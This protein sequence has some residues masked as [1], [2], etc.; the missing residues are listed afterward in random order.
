M[1]RPE[2]RVLQ[3]AKG[4]GPWKWGSAAVRCPGSEGWRTAL[5]AA[6]E[7]AD[8]VQQPPSRRAWPV[9]RSRRLACE[10][11]LQIARCRLPRL[12]VTAGLHLEADSARSHLPAD[13][14]TLN[15]AFPAKL[16]NLAF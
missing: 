6:R 3:A 16:L 14:I 10:I 12:G 5:R 2:V 1:W 9:V 8:R 7:V 11:G 13:R 4:T 15:M